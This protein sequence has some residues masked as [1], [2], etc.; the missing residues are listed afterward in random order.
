MFPGFASTCDEVNDVCTTGAVTLTHTCDMTQ[1]GAEC[2][3][4]DDCDSGVCLAD[5]TCEA[6]EL[7]GDVNG[8]CVVNIYD[9]SAVARAFNSCS[10]SYDPRRW[11]CRNP[12]WNLAADINMDGIVNFWDLLLV[13][14]NYGDTC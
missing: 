8:D 4:G 2:E 9:L 6:V 10:E 3:T 1:C 11:E 7:E 12:N 5:C 14:K 13:G